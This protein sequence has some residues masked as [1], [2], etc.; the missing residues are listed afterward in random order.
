MTEPIE[1][2][3]SSLSFEAAM[4]QLEEIVRKFESGGLTLEE[5]VTAYER[6]MRLRQYCDERLKTA[7]LRMEQ[8]AKNAEEEKLDDS[9][10]TV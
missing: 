1:T 3:I 10:H 9:D 2:E 5:S 6:G 4:K 7:K 8:V